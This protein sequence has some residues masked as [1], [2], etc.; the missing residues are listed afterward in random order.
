MS[1]LTRTCTMELQ[2]NHVHT[3]SSLYCFRF[4]KIDICFV[5]FVSII[6][7][8][9]TATSPQPSEA[10]VSCVIVCVRMYITLCVNAC[11]YVYVCAC[12][13]ACLC[14]RVLCV[15]GARACRC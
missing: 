1:E 7:N 2:A 11:V 5:K 12:V 14:M 13:F 15:C 3:Y 4:T 6:S 10:L 8:T 9:S